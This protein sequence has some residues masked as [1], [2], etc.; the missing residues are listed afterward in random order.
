MK[1]LRRSLGF[2]QAA[3]ACS[4]ASARRD[5]TLGPVL[6]VLPLVIISFVGFAMRGYTD[7]KFAIGIID[8]A[9]TPA[10]RALVAAIAGEQIVRERHYQSE[11]RM[12]VAVFRG[13][14]NGGLVIPED[15]NGER[16]LEMYLSAASP[17]S[18]VVQTLL[19][20]KLSAHAGPPVTR[21]RVE[22]PDG[23]PPGR[24][25]V[26][27]QYTAPGNL[28]LFIMITA[29]VSSMAIVGL[30]SSGLSKRLLATPARNAELFLVL[31]TGPVQIM[32]VQAAF[33]IAVTALAFQVPWGDPLGIFVITVAL[34]ALGVSLVFL[35]GTI[36]RTQ[37]QAGAV[38]PLLGVALAMLGGCM[39][40]VEIV[41]PFM[42]TLSLASPARWAMDGYLAL[43]FNRADA[44]SVLPN[45][46]VLLAMAA[47]L[48]TLGIL[49][50]RPQFSR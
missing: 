11:N 25:R 30:R 33:L 28:V 17:S 35:M 36:F 16:D 50:L 13:R 26:G 1:A 43:I 46:A 47:A 14:L 41:P 5:R 44:A 38:G 4:A 12:R 27:F 22:S 7:P 32:I 18:P 40:P 23:G 24:L 49:R 31:A 48:V 15:W 20:A 34:I 6:L 37:E 39:W 29:F 9:E 21:V 8:R 3:A 10:S 2:V 45:A 42:K 19:N